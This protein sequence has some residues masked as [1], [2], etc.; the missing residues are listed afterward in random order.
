MKIQSF[1]TTPAGCFEIYNLGKDIAPGTTYW[2]SQWAEQG[3]LHLTYNA[4]A[5]R[6][7]VPESHNREIP[8]LR[9]G[10]KRIVV[11]MVPIEHLES[12][13]FAV[14][15]MIEDGTDSPWVWH[16]SK[17]LFD[18]H[19]CPSTGKVTGIG[20]VWCQRDGKP[21]KVIERPAYF[22]TVEHLP[23]LSA[24]LPELIMSL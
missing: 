23:F 21:H 15:F 17:S 11:S 8:S 2:K 24:V 12:S 16:G 22:Q 18:S 9:K 6:L 1:Q 3:C 19:F 14:E 7:L 13:R 10:A 5:A 4:G 20:S